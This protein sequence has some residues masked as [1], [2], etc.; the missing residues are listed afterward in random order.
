[1][2]KFKLVVQGETREFEVFREGGTLNIQDGADTAVLHLIHIDEHTILLEREYPDGRR[3][4]IRV[5]G[6]K[7]GDKRALWVNGRTFIAERVRERGAG[8]SAA[9]SSL[10]ATIPAVVTDILVEVGE[11]VS[12]GDRLIL[13]ESM[14]MVIPI[15]APCDGVVT[16]VHCATGESVQAGV[17][18]IELEEKELT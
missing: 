11:R 8:A 10:S 1:M 2:T 7:Q 13:L 6:V 18:L 12:A 5:A 3:Q 15:Q 17:Q 14:K 16:A 9:D 4:Q